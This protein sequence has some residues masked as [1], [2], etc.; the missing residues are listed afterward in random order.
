[1]SDNSVPVLDG[2][3]LRKLAQGHSGQPC[4]SCAAI[5]APGWE[6]IPGSL[7]RDQLRKLGTLRRPEVED[8][9]LEEY[10]P[11]GTNSWSPD[12]PIA[13]AFFPY[14][15]CDV[16]ACVQ[17]GRPFLRYTEYGGYYVEERVREL[18]PALLVDGA[19]LPK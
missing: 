3:G 16:W 10:H 1:M 6:A 15:R 7:D 18:Q 19:P 11:R 4:P 14:N 13:P 17:C 9:T 5:K 2:G 12:A 8:P